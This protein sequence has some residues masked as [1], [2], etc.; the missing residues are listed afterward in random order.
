M[1]SQIIFRFGRTQSK[2]ERVG[3]TQ[4]EIGYFDYIITWAR[5]GTQMGEL[6]EFGVNTPI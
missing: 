3:K 1:I 4:Y 2:S 5:R 6:V